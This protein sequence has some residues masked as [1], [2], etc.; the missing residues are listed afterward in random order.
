MVQ[1]L[2]TGNLDHTSFWRDISLENNQAPTRLDRVAQWMH[3]ILARRLHRP[4]GFFAQCSSTRS[5]LLPIDQTSGNKPLNQQGHSAG[6]I[7]VD[8]HISSARLQIGKQRRAPAD[9]IEIVYCQR[10][11]CLA[12][13]RQQVQHG[14]GRTTRCRYTGDCILKSLAGQNVTRRHTAL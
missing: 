14:I 4:T 6:A 3:H 2:V 12:G 8:S 5:H 1:P 13:H 10:H 7:Q 11:A 9:R